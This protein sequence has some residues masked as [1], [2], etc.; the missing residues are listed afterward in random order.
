MPHLALQVPGDSLKEYLGQ[1][2]DPP[3]KGGNGQIRDVVSEGK[4]TD[5]GY[6]NMFHD[7]MALNA[8]RLL[9]PRSLLWTSMP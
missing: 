4:P 8:T 5:K 9:S 1:W 6:R 2:N 3:Y 7:E